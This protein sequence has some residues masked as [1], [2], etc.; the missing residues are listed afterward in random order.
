MN[1]LLKVKIWNKEVGRLMWHNGRHTSYFTYNPDF[2]NGDIDIAPLAASIKATSSRF[3]IYGENERIY[4]KLPSFLADSLP[5]DW[6]NLVFERWRIENNIRNTDITSIEKLA[7]IGKRGMGALEFEPE[8]ERE[9]YATTLELKSLISLAEKI[10]KEREQVHIFP[11]ESL[12]MQALI[13]VGTS[14]GGRQPKAI[15]SI[16]QQTGEIRSGQIQQ[17]EEYDY[18]ILKF[19]DDARSL[20]E[21]E[22]TFTEMAKMAGIETAESRLLNVGG[23]NHFLSK[24]FDR[25]GTN[26]IHCQTL[27]AMDPEAD[28]YEKLLTVCRK[29]NLGEPTCEQLFRR[30]VFNILANNTDDHNKNFTFLMTP[31]NKWRLSPAYDITYI[32]DRG[33]YLPNQQHCLTALGKLEDFT[34]KDMISFAE[35]NGIRKAASI[36]N[37]VKESILSFK[38]LA[39]K[40]EVKKEWIGRIENGLK[41][42]LNVFEDKHEVAV[43]GV[44]TTIENN[45][46]DSIV[47]EA[48]YKGN[49][50]L[51]ATI[52]GRSRKYI[53]RKGTPEHDAITQTGI[54]N[55]TDDYKAQLVK[56][57]I[58]SK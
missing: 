17:P 46:V 50:H 37:N 14:A 33:G 45:V 4:Q 54:S 11:D 29:L 18:Y 3:P 38:S 30:M 36:I 15:V 2:L 8:T 57:F 49:Y 41:D 42:N 6:G 1:P 22:Q 55:L 35:R 10:A 56:K 23:T 32:Y 12:T 5:D 51:I 27:A 34:Q 44:N 21:T 52:E 31:N 7:F 53:I 20:S 16:N 9:D 26:K 48:V 40:N 24:R 39:E 13:S 47:I 25:N 58:L 43:G 28:S 19:G